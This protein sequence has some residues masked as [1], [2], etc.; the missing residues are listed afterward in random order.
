MEK[1]EKS[2]YEREKLKLKPIE[3][4]KSFIE[5]FD[6]KQKDL[7]IYFGSQSIVSEVLNNKRSIS[8]EAAKKLG[9]RFSVSPLLFLDI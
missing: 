5:D 6:L 9:K 3:L 2:K 4:L 8:I 1:Y 7:S